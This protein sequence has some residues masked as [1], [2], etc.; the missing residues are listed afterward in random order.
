[1]FCVTLRNLLYGRD[2]AMPKYAI[3]Y[4]L[5]STSK[6]LKKTLLN[7]PQT[8]I[9]DLL[10]HLHFEVMGEVMGED[11]VGTLQRISD[12]PDDPG[13]GIAEALLGMCYEYGIL[14]QKDESTAF[15]FY[16]KAGKREGVASAP[17][18][19]CLGR[20][21]R[22]ELNPDAV[23]ENPEL[24]VKFL[25]EAIELG[26]LPA[27][28]NLAFEYKEGNPV[29]EQ[30]CALAL[31]L[32]EQAVEEGDAR[33]QFFLADFYWEG[34]LDLKEEVEK[35]RTLYRC[36]A[37]QGFSPAICALGRGYDDDKNE[38]RALGFEKDIKQAEKLYRIAAYGGE[39]AA[40][41]L[42]GNIYMRLES[43]YNCPAVEFKFQARRFFQEGV[44]GGCVASKRKLKELYSGGEAGLPKDRIR[45]AILARS[46][47]LEDAAYE[48][49]AHEDEESAEAPGELVAFLP[50]CTEIPESGTPEYWEY[51]LIQILRKCP[52]SLLER[53]VD[54]L[55]ENDVVKGEMRLLIALAYS[56]LGYCYQFGLE[57]LPQ[58]FSKAI[59][60]YE[61]AVE[62]GY[63]PSFSDLSPRYFSSS[64]STKR[65]KRFHRE[66]ENTAPEAE[67][68]TPRSCEQLLFHASICEK[69]PD[70]GF[71]LFK[72]LTYYQKACKRYDEEIQE[73]TSDLKKL[74]FQ[75]VEEYKFLPAF[76]AK[77][78]EALAFVEEKPKPI[79]AASI[80]A[81]IAEYAYDFEVI[82]AFVKVEQQNLES[83]AP[84]L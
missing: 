17:G 59:K 31:N 8:I 51:A 21:Y 35:V 15:A 68:A 69:V 82:K 81:E 9:D 13:V 33:A 45:A 54:E 23:Q 19:Y 24:E 78:A 36:S 80:I 41:F 60:F 71:G 18:K 32:F 55:K 44:E 57:E 58:D 42:L 30:D 50:D 27:K 40:N 39:E 34:E 2:K 56:T 48:N 62:Y 74:A 64:S 37:A 16:Q 29:L 3:E 67:Q 43:V 61:K 6:Y 63:R 38:G 20:A 47:A 14:V 53:R 11:V 83:M 49:A 66:L 1:M 5:K 7:F 12:N 72:A 77:I 76:K 84:S 26:F 46:V 70:L 4:F 22:G 28:V 65:L 25:K 73:G 52:M 79:L 10:Q 75:K